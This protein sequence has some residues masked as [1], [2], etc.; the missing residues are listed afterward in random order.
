M[1]NRNIQTLKDFREKNINILN[2]IKN[3]LFLFTSG[4][5]KNQKVQFNSQDIYYIAKYL[6]KLKVIEKRQLYASDAVDKLSF[7]FFL[8]Y[9]W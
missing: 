2:Q 7:M 6:T 1:H 3:Y 8:Y 4:S 9:K 5:T